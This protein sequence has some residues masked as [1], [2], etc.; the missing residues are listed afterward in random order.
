MSLLMR[1][2]L[3]TPLALSLSA[4]ISFAQA[5]NDICAN[6]ISLSAGLSGPYSNVGSNT[7][8]A[9]PCGTGGA[10]LWFT[11]TATCNGPISFDTCNVGTNF[12]TTIEVLTNDCNNPISLGCNDDSCGQRS[13]AV[14]NATL[15]TTYLVRVGGY[16]G[17]RFG[18]FYVNIRCTS[19]PA[20]DECT[21]AIAVF[22]GSNGIFS[23]AN[24]TDSMPFPCEASAGSDVW[25]RYQATCTGPVAFDTCSPNTTFDTV[26]EVFD[27]ACG[28]LNPLGCDDDTCN[29]TSGVVVVQATTGGIYFVHVGGWAQRQGTFDLNINCV[30]LPSNDECAGS[31]PLSTGLN[32]PFNNRYSTS[33]QPAWSCGNGGSDVWFS[34]FATCSTTVTIDLCTAFTDFDTALEVM[35]GPCGNQ[36]SLVCNDDTCGRASSVQ[37]AST[38]NTIYYLRVGGYNAKQGNF[39]IQ[40]SLAGTG[41]FSTQATGCGQATISA[42]GTPNLGSDVQFQID[43]EVGTPFLWIGLPLGAPLCPPATCTIGATFESVIPGDSLRAIIP[44]DPTLRGGNVLIQGADFGGIG[45]CPAPLQISLTNTIQVTIG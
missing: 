4:A 30:T 20:N 33:S 38:I 31:I 25:F 45:G 24:S 16:A 7:E 11:H 29:D 6:A 40:V 18:N 5:P 43:N 17:A 27:G 35:T 2:A 10:D 36:F 19:L 41:S 44:C 34:Y 37:F 12:D 39:E 15:G 13:T 14:I 22:N 3:C 8:L 32:G 21:G 9:W 1:A 23:N 26:I 28:V 42:S